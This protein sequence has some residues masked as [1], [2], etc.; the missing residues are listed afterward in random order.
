MCFSYYY[1]NSIQKKM[2]LPPKFRISLKIK[3]PK[4]R[5]LAERTLKRYLKEISFGYSTSWGHN[6]R[7]V[8]GNT[9]TCEVSDGYERVDLDFSKVEKENNEEE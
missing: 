4:S 2:K 6:T 1:K 7:G 9:Y 8:S 3:S 5:K